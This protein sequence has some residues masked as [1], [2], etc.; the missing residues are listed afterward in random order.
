MSHTQPS[1]RANTTNP[2]HTPWSATAAVETTIPT[3]TEFLAMDV[4]QRLMVVG[5]L[6]EP[7]V[8]AVASE[9][10]LAQARIF[11]AWRL[12]YP[13]HP[14]WRRHRRE[15][16]AEVLGFNARRRA[17]LMVGGVAQNGV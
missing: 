16:D 7:V 9:G 3:A 14:E 1:R 12:K 11:E 5:M 4:S 13:P 6:A 2:N 17:A 10:L 15:A 8:R